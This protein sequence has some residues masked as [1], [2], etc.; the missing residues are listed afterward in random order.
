LRTFNI[1]RLTSFVAAAQQQ[2]DQFAD[3]RVVDAISAI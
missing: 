2:E 3:A 1:L